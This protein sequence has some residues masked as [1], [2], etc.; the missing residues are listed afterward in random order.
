L[1]RADALDVN[2]T[3]AGLD[4][5]YRFLLARPPDDAGRRHYLQ[6]IRDEGMTL[7]EVAA[8]IALSDEFQ[9]RLRGSLSGRLN[10]DLNESGGES[11]VDVRELAAAL[12]VDVGIGM[13]GYHD[14]LPD[15]AIALEEVQINRYL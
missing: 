1:R 12:S 13:S 9:R 7:R 6:L 14:R 4:L 10:E 11:A 15:L 3:E 5:V 2:D 8:E